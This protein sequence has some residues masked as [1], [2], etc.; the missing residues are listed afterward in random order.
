MGLRE[1]M[2]LGDVV[3]LCEGELNEGDMLGRPV[4]K[5]LGDV[6]GS[7]TVGSLVGLSVVGLLVGLFVGLTG[8]KQ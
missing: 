2:E 4:G 5:T 7:S 1:G 3:G 6:L 8:F